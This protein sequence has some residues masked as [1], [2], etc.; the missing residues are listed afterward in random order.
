MKTRQEMVYEFMVA[1]ASNA[2]A[3]DSSRD[4]DEYYYGDIAL[5]VES[6]ACALADQFIEEHN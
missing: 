2:Q 4:I 1:L 3:C 6:M 5:R